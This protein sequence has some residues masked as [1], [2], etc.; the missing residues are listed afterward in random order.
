MGFDRD[1]NS[2]LLEAHLD[3]LASLNPVK[4]YLPH[5]M[6]QVFVPS[7]LNPRHFEVSNRSFEDVLEDANING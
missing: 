1:P 6:G 4:D 2:V 5:P 7:R 3:G